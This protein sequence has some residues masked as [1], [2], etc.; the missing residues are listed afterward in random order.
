[1]ATAALE[2]AGRKGY[3]SAYLDTEPLVMEAAHRTY[4]KAGFV[5]YD[6]RG[7]GPAS[8]SFLRKSLI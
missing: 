1:L 4:L 2:L 8:V 5:E 3:K 6:G 7:A